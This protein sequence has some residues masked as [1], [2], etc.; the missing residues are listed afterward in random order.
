[1]LQLRNSAQPSFIS[2]RSKDLL[3]YQ[4]Y[5]RPTHCCFGRPKTVPRSTKSLASRGSAQSPSVIS[6]AQTNGSVVSPRG[7]SQPGDAYRY[8]ARASLFAYSQP[9]C[10]N[11]PFS[12]QVALAFLRSLNSRDTPR[13][14]PGV[15]SATAIAVYIYMRHTFIMNGVYFV[16]LSNAF[17]FR[18]E[19][20]LRNMGEASSP[21]KHFR[22]V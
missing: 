5:G 18:D 20:C 1:M 9:C 8:K 7:V 12:I 21:K 3:V 11:T 17:F 10:L 2:D 19:G 14:R 15:E 13:A 22:L 4:K 6:R 16:L